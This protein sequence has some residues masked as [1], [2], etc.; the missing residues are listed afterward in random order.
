MGTTIIEYILE[1]S[2]I[3]LNNVDKTSRKKLAQIFTPVELAKFMCSL[4]PLSNYSTIS[5]L[6]PGAGSGILTGSLCECILSYPNIT[7][8]HVDL[9]EIDS[10][11][12][13]ILSN[14][15]DHIVSVMKENNKVFTYRIYN[16]NFILTNS[17]VWLAP[18]NRYDFVL[19]NPPYHKI[20]A[21]SPEAQ[22]MSSLIK[23]QPNI[24]PLFMALSTQLLKP[25]GIM[26]FITPRIFC[27]G[28]YYQLFRSWFLNNVTFRH[29]HVFESRR[30]LF[31]GILQEAIII[32]AEKIDTKPKS[33]TIS[34]TFSTAI[35]EASYFNCSYKSI[36]QE[37]D[38]NYLIKLPTL[39][40]DYLVMRLIE[41][42]PNTLDS[43]RYKVSTGPIVDFRKKANLVNCDKACKK[44][45]VPLIWPCNVKSQFVKWPIIQNKKPQAIIESGLQHLLLPNGNYLVISRLPMV[46]NQQHL[47]CSMY[48]KDCINTHSI[49][50]ENHLNYLTSYDGHLTAT[51]SYGL[52]SILNSSLM[53]RYITILKGKSLLNAS[54]LQNLPMPSIEDI[55]NIGLIAQSIE[56]LDAERCSRILFDYFESVKISDAL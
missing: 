39:S 49:G 22:V 28:S 50:I 16:E 3:Y 18:S 27:S 31:P 25:H 48:L 40:T 20:S 53:F 19:C 34:S 56:N 42:W 10:N 29:I 30:S 32:K 12:V 47:D 33:I 43:L 23:G 13:P 17:H 54:D 51:E 55:H 2:A 9:Y 45:E 21:D 37:K 46:N 24:F 5:F 15:M 14:N 41:S 52:Y 11:L 38:G 7:T 26:V 36:V 6:D 8:V 35:D 44:G 1:S 4:F